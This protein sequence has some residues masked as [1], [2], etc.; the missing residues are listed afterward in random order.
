MKV[1]MLGWEYP[2]HITGGL[3]TACEGLTQA[4]SR[5]GIDVQFVVPELF[6]GESA[7]HMTLLD[8][9]TAGPSPASSTSAVGLPHATARAVVP[10]VTMGA[11][12]TEVEFSQNILNLNET[13]TQWAQTACEKELFESSQ[14]PVLATGDQKVPLRNLYGKDIFTEVEYYARRVLRRAAQLDFDVVHAH[15]W[16]TF[17]AGILVSRLTNKPLIVHVHSLEYDRSGSAVHPTI[18]GIER[19]GIQAADAVIAVSDYTKSVILEQHPIAPHK[20]HVIHNGVTQVALKG[21]GVSELSLQKRTPESKIVLFLG[22]VTF[23]KGPDYFVE[24]AAKVVQHVP[25]A[26][27]VL[28]GHGD[29]LPRLIHR[30]HELGIEGSFHF[31]GFLRG[32]EVE[33]MMRL[34]D[35]YVMPSV[36]EPFGI[37][38]LE[39]IACDTPALISRQSGVSEVL[40]HALK[41]DFWDVDRMADLMINALLSDALRLDMVG[42]AQ[43]QVDR[44]RWDLSARKAVEV[45]KT[46]AA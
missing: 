2:P 36:S 7:P 29:M 32:N 30:V 20:L 46:L 4:L 14:A 13:L 31:P 44:L 38:A 18:H 19:I 21:A 15:D 24:A 25:G 37:A 34:A 5:N 22:R 33:Q 45:Y 35:L 26:L 9:R 41:V 43:Q 3:G 39:A 42:M 17:P 40:T 23:Q 12:T 6:G 27:F 10:L 28:A 11:Y 16:M 1:L 8:S